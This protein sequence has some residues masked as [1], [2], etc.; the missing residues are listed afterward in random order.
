MA[1]MPVTDVRPL[2][3]TEE[4]RFELIRLLEQALQETRVEIHRTHTP[5]YRKRVIGE[6]SLVRSLLTKLQEQ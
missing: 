5:G 4:E 6:E 1:A 3:I 2:S